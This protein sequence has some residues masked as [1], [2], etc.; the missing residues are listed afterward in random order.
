MTTRSFTAVVLLVASSGCGG[1][2]T[3]TTDTIAPDATETVTAT[4]TTAETATDELSSS[5][6]GSSPSPSTVPS[7]STTTDSMAVMDVNEATPW[8]VE[9]ADPTGPLL[10]DWATSAT[11]RPPDAAAPDGVDASLAWIYAELIE[12]WRDDTRM[13]AL[14]MTEVAIAPSHRDVVPGAVIDI[15]GSAAAALADSYA[16]IA[17]RAAA[18]A[19]PGASGEP[20]FAAWS[21]HASRSV[22]AAEV[23]RSG[24]AGARSLPPEDQA[25]FL[26]VFDGDDG[27]DGAGADLAVTL[28]AESEAAGQ[29]IDV[30]DLEELGTY[31]AFGIPLDECA[32]W[33]QAAAT[34]GL[35]DAEEAAIWL[36]VDDHELDVTFV[37]R[38]E[39]HGERDRIEDAVAD[40]VADRAWFRGY[41]DAV[42]AAV[43][44]SGYDEVSAEF[45]NGAE[46][47][48]REYEYRS[49]EA[50]T[51]IVDRA[52][53]VASNTW[54]HVDDLALARVL[55][56]VAAL[57]FDDW[58]KLGS[59]E[60]AWADV[61]ACDVWTELQ[62]G[63][64]DEL[65]EASASAF[66]VAVAELEIAGSL[67]PDGCG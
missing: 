28:L 46:D 44:E 7:S 61:A 2:D 62:E 52:R 54:A 8:A 47:E 42:V 16:V 60:L 48:R 66:D 3:E 53:D 56:E 11:Y 36:A 57:E 24:L 14:P 67:V 31:R 17:D 9:L 58:V 22:D 45:A 41:L 4:D 5:V 25:C 64:R 18:A 10:E 43:V 20:L 49:A 19:V 6:E 21:E 1:A 35:T 65:E 29:A 63:L 15:L 13:R 32:A 12:L 34:T 51:L 59:Y 37:A 27:C 39:C 30:V 33:E 55:Y 38:S 40:E 26:A 50:T 23:L